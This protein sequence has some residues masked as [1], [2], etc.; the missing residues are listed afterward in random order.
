MSLF[1]L[2]LMEEDSRKLADKLLKISVELNQRNEQLFENDFMLTHS[3]HHTARLD[4]EEKGTS[5]VLKE[6]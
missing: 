4:G 5:M 6:S 1:Q 3:S 2:G